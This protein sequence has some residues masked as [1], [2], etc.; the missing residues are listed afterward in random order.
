MNRFTWTLVFLVLGLFDAGLA[1]GQATRTWVSGVGD[2]AN[3]CSRTA[4]CLTFAGT[5]AKTAA[6]G[7][8]SVLDPGDFGPVTITKA[9]TISGDGTL[10]G[11]TVGAAENGINVQ[12]GANDVVILRNLSLTS[13]GTGIHGISYSSGRHL[14]VDRCSINR[15]SQSGVEVALT[16]GGALT[17]TGTSVVGGTNGIRIGT[18]ARLDAE[19][20]EVAI[21]KAGNGINVQSGFVSIRDSLIAQNSGVGV[22]SQAGKVAIES[23]KINGNDTAVQ[24]LGGLARLSNSSFYNNQNGLVCSGGP[25]TSSHDNRKG[26]NSGGSVSICA[27]PLPALITL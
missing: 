5:L 13:D 18:S 10:A 17:I 26:G 4:P 20:H 12:A 2:D 15:M 9:M 25:I 3:P 21:L 19:I 22:L 27:E 24:V 1:Y 7:E 16:A 8:I 23:T 11:I 14:I 6:G